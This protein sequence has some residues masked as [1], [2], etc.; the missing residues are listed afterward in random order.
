MKIALISSST[1]SPIAR[2][3]TQKLH[4]NEALRQEGFEYQHIEL[5]TTFFRSGELMPELPESVR[6]MQVYLFHCPFWP[7]ANAGLMEIFLATN[8]IRLASAEKLT[9]VPTYIPYLR[10]D[11]KDEKDGKVR[12]VPISAKVI[13]N[14]LFSDPI[15]K[16]LISFDMHAEQEEGFFPGPAQNLAGRRLFA[17]YFNDMFNGDFTDVH[18]CSTDLGGGKRVQRLAHLMDPDI[19]V[20][21]LL[22]GRQKGEKVKT[23]GYIGDDVRGKTVILNDDMFDSGNSTITGINTLMERGA[24]EVIACATHGIFVPDDDG[25]A[26]EKFKKLGARVITLD[27]IPRSEAYRRENESWLTTLPIDEF[28]ARVI[29]ESH[30]AGGSINAVR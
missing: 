9:I 3:I 7:N 25:P 4:E 27:T 1:M 12:R 14:F 8:A 22:K 5:A 16:E 13:A 26:E 11:R 19:P 24:K 10:Q 20:G 6:S 30:R 18:V 28:L 15:V 17:D 21:I 29:C 23:L 2:S